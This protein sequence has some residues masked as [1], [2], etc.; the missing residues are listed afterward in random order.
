MWVSLRCPADVE[1][2]IGNILRTILDWVVYTV[3][4]LF[5]AECYNIGGLKYSLLCDQLHEY[6]LGIAKSN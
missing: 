1:Q 2:D 6:V 3:S 4:G 5:S